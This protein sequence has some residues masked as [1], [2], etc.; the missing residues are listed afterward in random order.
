MKNT[1]SLIEVNNIPL[2]VRS[3]QN[4]E[5]RPTIVFLH[6]SLGC[7]QLWWDFPEKLC[8]AAAYNILVYDR[9]GYGKSAALVSA[10]RGNDYLENETDTLRALLFTLNVKDAIAFGHSDGGSIALIAAGKYP[11]L[12]SAV[13]VEAAHI[14]VEQVTLAGIHAAIK[15]YADTNLKSRLEKY[16][17]NK[18]DTLFK[19]W[20]QTWTSDKF[21]TWNMEHFLPSIN[22][23]IL[24]IQGE[25]DE[26]GT[27]EQMQGVVR[28]TK[29]HVELYL[30][31]GVGHTP[32][33]QAGEEIIERTAAF[34]RT[35]TTLHQ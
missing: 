10:V 14:F 16:H 23:P 25:Q 31:P 21:K 11:S 17:G 30:I 29:A 6:D 19:A 13:V 2:Y 27:A 4:F 5:N 12:F 22:C 15:E 18:T 3:V 7:T 1:D 24:F 28:N 34:I 8:Q 32:H 26:Y 9:Q 20:T 35:H 33:K